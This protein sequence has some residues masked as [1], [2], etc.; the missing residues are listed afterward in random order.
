M[1]LSDIS[2]IQVQSIDPASNSI[3]EE[4]WKNNVATIAL[5]AALATSVLLSPPVLAQSETHKEQIT[6]AYVEMGGEVR[7]YDLGDKFE[8]AKEAE[9]F[10]SKVLD[11]NGVGN[12]H[13]VIKK[14]Y[15]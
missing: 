3:I 4:G 14:G 6:I 2:K 9:A 10:I 12:Y 5:G 7:K 13:V 11:N 15:K 8:T 1:K